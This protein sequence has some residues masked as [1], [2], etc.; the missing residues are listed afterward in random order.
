MP[1][2][3][4]DTEGWYQNKRSKDLSPIERMAPTH[5][6]PLLVG[7]TDGPTEEQAKTMIQKHMTNPRRLAVGMVTT[8]RIRLQAEPCPFILKYLDPGSGRN[9]PTIWHGA[10]AYPGVFIP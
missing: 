5:F 10:G 2:L 4:N 7:P 9:I 3:W 1:Q 6:Y 8:L